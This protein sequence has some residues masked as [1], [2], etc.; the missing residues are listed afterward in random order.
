MV[1]LPKNFDPSKPIHLVVYDHGWYDNAKSAYNKSHLA[2]QMA[3]APPNTVLI[4]PEW[5]KTPGSSGPEGGVQGEFSKPGFLSGMV[6]EIFDKTPELKNKTLA[7]VDHIGIISHSA[8]FH[9]AESEVYNN[10]EFSKKIDSV[11]LLDSLYNGQG[12]DKWIQDNIN[13]LSAGTKHFHNI[14][15]SSTAKNSKAQAERVQKMLKDAGLP[16][17]SVSVVSE[18]QAPHR[19]QID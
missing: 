9:A 13:D 10:G 3:K 11:T 5:Q 2:E 16:A 19:L 6:Q 1:L 8:G 12:F 15:N 17:D 18:Q 4:V 7:D 14:F